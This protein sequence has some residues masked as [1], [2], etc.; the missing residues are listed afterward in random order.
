MLFNESLFIKTE[1]KPSQSTFMF[2]DV[3]DSGFISGFD[4]S[5]LSLKYIVKDIFRQLNQTLMLSWLRDWLT[6]NHD[7]FPNKLI[8]G[9]Q[10]REAIDGSR[11]TVI[12]F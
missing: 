7:V 11:T 9:Y 4:W 6:P 2:G 1:M 10:R 8:I 5:H 3:K 12:V